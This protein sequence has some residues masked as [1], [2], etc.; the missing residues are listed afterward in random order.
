MHAEAGRAS[1]H[2][3]CGAVGVA[4]RF[5]LHSCRTP[6]FCPGLDS[7]HTASYSCICNCS[8]AVC[9]ANRRVARARTGGFASA[10]SHAIPWACRRQLVASA[11][12]CV[13]RAWSCARQCGCSASCRRQCAPPPAAVSADS[14][15]ARSSIAH[16]NQ[17]FSIPKIPVARRRPGA[18]EFQPAQV[19]KYPS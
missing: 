6:Y 9:A 18:G 19:A 5:P 2:P 10:L 7:V 3:L 1:T 14:N 11:T 13:R 17:D 8:R 4:P 12:Y 15:I 16:K